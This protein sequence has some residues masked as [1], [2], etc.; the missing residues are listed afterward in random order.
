[1]TARA[2]LASARPDRP[3]RR[4]AGRIVDLLFTWSERAWQRRQLS[5]LNDYML[6]DMGLSAADV[7]REVGKP[8]WRP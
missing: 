8:F 7:Q 5:G 2:F 6:K 3:E 1:M 4:S